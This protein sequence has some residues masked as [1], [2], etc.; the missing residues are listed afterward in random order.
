MG[1][2]QDAIYNWLTIKI[3][4]DHRPTDRSAAD[5]ASLFHQVLIEDHH[6][7]ELNV[8]HQPDYYEV[9]CVING[10]HNSYRFPRE[11]VELFVNQMKENPEHYPNYE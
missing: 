3:V 1:T 2:L 7:D 10:H 6:V 4:S 5:T 9:T 8:L 11:T